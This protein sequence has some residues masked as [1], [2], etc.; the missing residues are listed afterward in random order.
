MSEPNKDG[1]SN[2]AIEA[3]ADWLIAESEADD[4]EATDS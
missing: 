2:E 4:T 3:I 1:L